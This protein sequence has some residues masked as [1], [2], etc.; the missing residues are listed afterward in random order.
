MVFRRSTHMAL[1][2]VVTTAL[3]AAQLLCC[4]CTVHRSI[5]GSAGLLPAATDVG[6]VCC[7]SLPDA[8]DPSIA[9]HSDCC[10][11]EP[12]RHRKPTHDGHSCPC[13]SELRQPYVASA[14]FSLDRL[15]CHGVAP[16][17]LGDLLT[18]AFACR[19]APLGAENGSKEPVAFPH[20][21]P[22]AMLRALCL[23][24]C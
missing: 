8:T 13:Q 4:C 21:T 11:N 24:R 23:L 12:D 5:A 20:L 22:R 16:Q 17:P 1:T 9:H 10:S 15:E 18:L 7:C 3:L 6:S 14:P 19:L 2:S